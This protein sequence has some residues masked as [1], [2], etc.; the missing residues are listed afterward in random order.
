MHKTK[1]SNK[2]F[3]FHFLVFFQK[4]KIR[5]PQKSCKWNSVSKIVIIVFLRLD[6]VELYRF[7]EYYCLASRGVWMG[8]TPLRVTMNSYFHYLLFDI[9]YSHSLPPEL[10]M[11]RRNTRPK[12]LKNNTF[13]SS[14]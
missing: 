11:F 9:Q 13:I 6:S 5:F 7:L 10:Q 2:N 1:I 8:S 12:R 4:S 14:K 3:Y